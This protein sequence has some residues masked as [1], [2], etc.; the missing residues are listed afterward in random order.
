MQERFLYLLFVQEN[1]LRLNVLWKLQLLLKS[2][3]LPINEANKQTKKKKWERRWKGENIKEE[4]EGRKERINSIA[5]SAAL[6]LCKTA[7]CWR[8]GWSQHHLISNLRLWYIC[9]QARLDQIF[10]QPL[11]APRLMAAL[12]KM[13]FWLAKPILISKIPHIPGCMVVSSA[14]SL[15]LIC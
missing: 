8:K 4:E 2:W 11:W 10:F 9:I 12:K 6:P 5:K 3:L 7:C 13:Q 15:A 14:H 1:F